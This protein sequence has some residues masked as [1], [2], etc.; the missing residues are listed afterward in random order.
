M[1]H[2]ALAPI[3]VIAHYNLLETLDASGV[4]ELFR[5]RDTKHGRTVAVRLLA[6]EFAPDRKQFIDR[7]RQAQVLSHPNAITLFDVGEHDERVYIVFE[8]LKGQPLRSEMAGRAVNVRRAVEIA[9]QI[10][11]AVAEA[12][13][14]GFTHRGLS[15]DAIVITAKGNV[16]IPALDL[17]VQGG[18]ESITGQVRLPDY[19]APEEAQ[20]RSDDRSDV[21]S[22]GAILYEMLTM[23]RPMHRGASAPSASNPGVVK[24]LD[25]I[26]L[27]AVAPNPDSRYQSVAT[28]AAD[29]R[30]TAAA[31]AVEDGEGSSDQAVGPS[32]SMGGIL[33]M[34]TVMLAILAAIVWW[35]MRS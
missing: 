27:R 1:S 20:G 29:L 18:L 15:P 26:V 33:L 24:A 14:A 28:F 22:V 31:L 2:E 17:A 8:F 4:G 12:H 11:D 34:T 25:G 32:A 9:V 10:A 16:K 23:R 5:A 6:A 13:A 3:G 7:A 19:D 35:A 21:Y 30:S